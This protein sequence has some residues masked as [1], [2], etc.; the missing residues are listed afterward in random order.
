M[1]SARRGAGRELEVGDALRS[2]P[3]PD[4]SLADNGLGGVVA[5]PDQVEQGRGELVGAGLAALPQ[6]GGNQ[7]R[8]G[9]VGGSCSYS[10]S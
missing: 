1:E 2:Q 4:A 10:R 3:A 6:Q 5:T 9:F 8:R 7:S